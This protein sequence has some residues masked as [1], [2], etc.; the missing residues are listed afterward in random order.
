MYV[1]TVS[2]INEEQFADEKV[3]WYEIEFFQNKN[4]IT[5]LI[6]QSPEDKC[7]LTQIQ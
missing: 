1:Q 2:V 5:C 3:L 7:S 6:L 4:L